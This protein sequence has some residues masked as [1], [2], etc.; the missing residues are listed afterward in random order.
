MTKVYEKGSV[1]F[2]DPSTGKRV[3]IDAAISVDLQP[4]L[5][6]P[7]RPPKGITKMTA[8]FLLE[9][10]RSRLSDDL[11]EVYTDSLTG[12][13]VIW[14]PSTFDGGQAL[15]T[16][17]LVLEYAR[18]RARGQFRGDLFREREAVY[19]YWQKHIAWEV[20]LPMKHQFHWEPGMDEAF[21]YPL[22]VIP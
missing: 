4:A 17:I 15:W 6:A 3:T 12:E 18:A 13:R 16:M 2:C 5:P 11:V 10:V 22:G 14:F 8:T 7:P 20:D 1:S 21:E 9:G 19:E